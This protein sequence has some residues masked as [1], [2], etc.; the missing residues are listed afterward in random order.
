MTEAKKT[1]SE[2]KRADIIDGAQRAFKQFGV[3]NTSMDKVAEMAQVSKRTVY[4]H[5]ESKEVLVTH[6]IRHIWA[7]T[8]VAYDVVYQ[9]SRDI[10][11]QLFELVLNEIT[12]SQKEEFFELIRVAINYTFFGPDE[13]RN[14]INQFFKQDTALI[15]WLRAANNDHQFTDMD[16]IKA[17]DQIMGLLKG[18]SFW[19]QILRFEAP[20]N[21]QQCRDLAT[22]TVELMWCRYYNK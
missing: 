12:F 18:E 9:P 20:L 6:I 3:E 11:Q 1:R 17:N 10:K 8:I 5:F 16:P 2:L 7:T 14:E 13:F 21:D 15:R 22:Q 19:P 4:N